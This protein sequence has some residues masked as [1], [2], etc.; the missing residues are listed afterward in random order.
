MIERK[1]MAEFS[2]E[3]QSPVVETR[4]VILFADRSYIGAMDGEGKGDCIRFKISDVLGILNT[5]LE[6]KG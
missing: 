4:K 1:V 2:K 5:P 3:P 6:E